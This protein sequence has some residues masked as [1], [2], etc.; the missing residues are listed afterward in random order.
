MKVLLVLLRG[1]N[2]QV[3]QG[4]IGRITVQV[5]AAGE[6]VPAFEVF[7]A[8]SNRTADMGHGAAYY[9]KG[10]IE[11]AQFFSTGQGLPLNQ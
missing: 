10:K 7:D 1:N 4:I 6:L 8:V 5:Y 2:F 9:W 3:V 11:E